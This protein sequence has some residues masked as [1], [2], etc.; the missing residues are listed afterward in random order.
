MKDNFITIPGVGTLSQTLLEKALA[1]S[2]R[3]DW[4]DSKT[5]SYTGHLVWRMSGTGRGWRLHE[6]SIKPA[7]KTVRE[8]ID[9][10]RCND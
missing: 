3:L 1:D 5:G 8:A 6:T 4:L 2:A 10:V 7:Y 9:A